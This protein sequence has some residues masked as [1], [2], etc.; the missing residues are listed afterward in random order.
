MKDILCSTCKFWIPGQVMGVCRRY[1]EVFNKHERD[2]CGEHQPVP[3]LMVPI[4]NIKMRDEQPTP[5]KPGRKP[6]NVVTD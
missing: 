2:W 4:V 1:P 6:K 5:K 3:V